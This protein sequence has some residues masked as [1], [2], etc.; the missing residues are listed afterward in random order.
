MDTFRVR[1]QIYRAKRARAISGPIF[2]ENFERDLA[3]LIDTAIARAGQHE[4]TLNS[5]CLD[6]QT[7]SELGE[8][9]ADLGKMIANIRESVQMAAVIRLDRSEATAPGS[10]R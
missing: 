7:D 3:A 4:T 1:R 5:G 9:A 2:T 10:N 8:T 6:S